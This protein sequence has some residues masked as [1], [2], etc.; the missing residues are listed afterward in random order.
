MAAMAGGTDTNCGNPNFFQL[1]LGKAVADGLV[2]ERSVDLAFGRVVRMILRLGLLDLD[3]PYDHLNKGHVG[4]HSSDTLC[5]E[6]ARQSV[7]LLRNRNDVALPIVLPMD[8]P[9]SLALVGPHANTTTRL[10]GM[11]V[12]SGNRLITQR[13]AL[14]LMRA[15]LPAHQLHYAPGMLS[16]ES[17]DTSGF[18]AAVAATKRATTVVVMLGLCEQGHGCT[19]H[20][21]QDRSTLSLPTTQLALLKAVSTAAA[22]TN[23]VCVFISGGPLSVDALDELCDAALWTAYP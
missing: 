11:Y 8:S 10:L 2:D 15:R 19:E 13:S 3:M 16:L 14:F 4:A 18:A 6:A 22:N 20:E 17:T 12:G 9:R 7:V 1:Y 5:V 21:N 23:V